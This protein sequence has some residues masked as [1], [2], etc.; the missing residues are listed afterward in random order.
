MQLCLEIG[1]GGCV[2]P[3]VGGAAVRSVVGG[4]VVGGGMWD[5][6]NLKT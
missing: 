4:I 6:E 5:I 2:E 3:G 1:R